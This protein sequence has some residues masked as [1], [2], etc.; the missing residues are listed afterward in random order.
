MELFRLQTF[1]I[2]GYEC[3]LTASEPQTSKLQLRQWLFVRFQQDFFSYI[4]I[5][6]ELSP[7]FVDVVGAMGDS[8][9]VRLT[10]T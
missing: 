4:I 3:D 9:T 1:G 5:V 10:A 8:I 6:H 7:K 2:T